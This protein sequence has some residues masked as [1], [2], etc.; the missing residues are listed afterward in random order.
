MESINY[1]SVNTILAKFHR[2]IKEES[3]NESD[4]IEYIGE[5][6]G[7]LNVH[8]VK[9]QAVAFI[10]VKDYSCAVPKN[11]Q[12]VLQVA[13]HNEF[14]PTSKLECLPTI[15]AIEELKLELGEMSALDC[16]DCEGFSEEVPEF[17]THFSLPSTYSNWRSNSYYREKFSPVRLA[18]HTFFNTLVC[19]E[20]EDS[21]YG[22][23]D[24]DCVYCKDNPN[25]EYTIVGT[26]DKQFR[27][28]FREGYV[29]IAYTRTPVDSETGYPL[30]PDNIRH[31]TAVSYYLKW[32][33]AETK[34]WQGREGFSGIADKAEA[35]W[36]KYVRQANNYMKMPKSL[37]DHQDLLEQSHY[38][39]PNH[40]RYYGFFGNLNREED[41]RFN[42]PNQTRQLKYYYTQNGRR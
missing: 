21:P 32:K 31:I 34:V 16:M 37:D 30:I 29:A 28:S 22:A 26:V 42:D 33:I 11:L 39:I 40:R 9:E 24:L 1:V 15:D 19:R 3:A 35:R 12:M 17:P 20:K 36:L 4:L 5:A 7:F 18:D 38:L 13:R 14:D 10:E 27:F 41:R 23:D 25:D 6:M 2:E 8:Q